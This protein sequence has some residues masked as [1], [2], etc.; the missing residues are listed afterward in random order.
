MKL[1][2]GTTGLTTLVGAVCSLFL[3]VTLFGF[4]LIKTDILLNNKKQDFIATQIKYGLNPLAVFDASHGLAI[5][6]GFTAYALNNKEVFDESIGTLEFKAYEWG[7]DESGKKF[8]R[9]DPIE[10]HFCSKEELGLE[11]NSSNFMPPSQQ[12][13]KDLSFFHSKL[14]CIDPS[15]SRIYG[16]FNSAAAR[17]LSVRLTRCSD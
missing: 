11:G 2:G 15:E 5:A 12:A 1:D 10:S 6:V 13:L 3:F 14:R 4:T 16:D 8:V 7:T 17:L 9:F